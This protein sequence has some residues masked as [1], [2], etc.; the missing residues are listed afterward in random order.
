MSDI[1]VCCITRHLGY[2]LDCDSARRYAKNQAMQIAVIKVMETAQG[3]LIEE[4]KIAWE[5]F[6][7]RDFVR[8]YNEAL[9]NMTDII[10]LI[11]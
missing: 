1:S 8:N 10:A 6:V 5:D 7:I 9:D 2:S 3:L 4:Q 11:R